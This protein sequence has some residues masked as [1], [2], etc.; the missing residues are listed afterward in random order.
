M[1][2]KRDL[3]QAVNQ[4]EFHVVE[5]SPCDIVF[6]ERVKLLCYY[7]PKYGTRR[8]CPPA[9]PSLDWKKL[10]QEY[11][12]CW[13]VY[14]KT[15]F[16]GEITK[17]SRRVS[18]MALYAQLYALEGLLHGSG[19]PLAVFFGGGSCKLCEGGIGC[20]PECHHPSRSRIPI[21][22]I[23]VNVV[24]VLQQVEVQLPFP[25]KDE[26]FRVGMLLW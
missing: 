2:E 5:I 9:V 23:G 13:I 26:Y 16:S 7:C 25:P 14:S 21:E 1:I 18:S 19:Y 8:T 10:V 17:E 20:S 4:T 12:N 6:E 24:K 15:S 11:E 22:A 3:L